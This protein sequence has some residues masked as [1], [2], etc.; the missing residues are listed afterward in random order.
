MGISHTNTCSFVGD[1]LFGLTIYRSNHV[2]HKG[3]SLLCIFEN[4]TKN[5]HEPKNPFLNK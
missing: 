1:M 4:C 3:A 5:L 2:N